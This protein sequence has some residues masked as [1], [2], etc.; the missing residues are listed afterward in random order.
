[1][2]TSDAGSLLKLKNVDKLRWVLVS[3][4][5]LRDITIKAYDYEFLDS[6]SDYPINSKIKSLLNVILAPI[7]VKEFSKLSVWGFVKSISIEITNT[8]LPFDLQIPYGWLE[9]LFN[10]MQ[11][12]NSLKLI[13]FTWNADLVHILRKYRQW[14]IDHLDI[15]ILFLNNQDGIEWDELFQELLQTTDS[16]SNLSICSSS[17]CMNPII[18]VRILDMKLWKRIYIVWKTEIDSG[19]FQILL[20]KLISWAN[21]NYN[22]ELCKVEVLLPIMMENVSIPENNFQNDDYITKSFVDPK[23]KKFTLLIMH[24]KLKKSK[25]SRQSLCISSTCKLTQNESCWT[26]SAGSGIL[27]FSKFLVQIP[28]IEHGIDSVN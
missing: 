26:D 18:L 28:F 8:F 12:I 14:K 16:L 6:E 7:A 13:G 15:E 22:L 27:L 17:D 5:L 9:V 1:M 10:K 2:Y 24:K 25:S 3:K 11:E 23:T 20:S 19:V 4:R 21:Y